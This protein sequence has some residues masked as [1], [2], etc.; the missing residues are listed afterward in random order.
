VR[1]ERGER[2]PSH[3]YMVF[4]FKLQTSNFKLPSPQFP[5]SPFLLPKDKKG[6]KKRDK[7]D[8]GRGRKK[9]KKGT[10]AQRHKDEKFE[11]MKE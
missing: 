11:G 3:H 1:G 7:K 4:P 8:R 2:V 10:H 6:Q 5:I 9:K